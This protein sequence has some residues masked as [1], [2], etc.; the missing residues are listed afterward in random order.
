MYILIVIQNSI[1]EIDTEH[2]CIL[3]N[4]K[5]AFL[6]QGTKPRLKTICVTVR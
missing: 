6:F 5:H 3:F 4:Y 1:A 2:K